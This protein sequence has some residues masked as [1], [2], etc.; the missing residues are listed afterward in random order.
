MNFLQTINNLNRTTKFFLFILV[1]S[2]LGATTFWV[3]SAIESANNPYKSYGEVYENE[4]MFVNFRLNETRS[5]SGLEEIAYYS[6]YTVINAKEGIDINKTVVYYSIETVTG[7]FIYKEDTP[8]NTDTVANWKP[9][10]L[11][12]TIG[13]NIDETP[14]NIYIKIVYEVIVDEMPSP[15]RELS[16]HVKAQQPPLNFGSDFTTPEISSIGIVSNEYFGMT[17]R[18]KLATSTTRRVQLI[19]S[20]KI[21]AGVAQMKISGYTTL[22]NHSTDTNN[23]VSDVLKY[24]EY[25][26]SLNKTLATFNGDIKVE[27]HPENVYFIIE[28]EFENG[29]KATFNYVFSINQ[30]P[31]Y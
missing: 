24:V 14:K 4:D 20:P 5:L 16:I 3:I 31:V 6:V 29:T 23:K 21:S 2:L 11:R 12:K 15:R 25:T 18:T 28:L 27:Y 13:T 7:K 19:I 26:G 9:N 1:T 30:I 17:I 10:L 22:D 8:Q